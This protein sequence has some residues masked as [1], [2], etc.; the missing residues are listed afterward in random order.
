MTW[1]KCICFNS[2]SAHLWK[3]S[4]P[5]KQKA[6][7]PNLPETGPSMPGRA[8]ARCFCAFPAWS[9]GWLGSSCETAPASFPLPQ[10]YRT[11]FL[12]W[13]C[14]STWTYPQK[15]WLMQPSLFSWHW[16]SIQA[17]PMPKLKTRTG[18]E[19]FPIN[20]PTGNCLLYWIL[21]RS[22]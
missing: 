17:K 15:V 1:H 10:R 19:W 16:G 4:L 12:D 6:H 13:N 8:N 11:G 20:K 21:V 18:P 14:P 9:G 2:T 5:R 3:K 7:T 22:T